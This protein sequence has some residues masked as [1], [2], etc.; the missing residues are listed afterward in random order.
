IPHRAT[1]ECVR[2]IAAHFE[3]HLDPAL[4]I[5]F[6]YSN[7]C[8]NYGFQ[9]TAYCRAQGQSIPNMDPGSWYGYRSA[10]CMKIVH[11][12]FAAHSRWRG[13]LATQ[14]VNPAVTKFAL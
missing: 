1:D 14:T 11:D 10:Q 13:C 4:I 5:T 12:I 7:E 3:K 9:Q 6:E 8:W 2:S